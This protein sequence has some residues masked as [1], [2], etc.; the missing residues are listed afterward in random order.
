MKGRYLTNALFVLMHALKY[1]ITKDRIPLMVSL[2][3][4]NLCN[5]DCSFCY[6]KNS[7]VKFSEYST[8]ELL[9]YIDQFVLLG[10]RIFLLQGGEPLLRQDLKE[11]ISRIRHREAFCR[12][13][14]NGVLVAQ[15]IDSLTDADQISFSLDGNQEVADK[16]R[17]SGVY[18]KVLEGMEEAFKRKIPFEIHASLIRESATHKDSVFHLLELARRFRT[19]V[20][21]CVSCVSGAQNT[22]T[23]GSADLTGEEIKDFYRFLIRLKKEKYPVG[24]SFNSLKKS[25]NWPISYSEIG[26]EHNLPVGF[27]FAP[28]RHGR[29]ICWLG[30]NHTLLPCP[31]AFSRPEYEVPI[32][33]HHIKE[34]WEELGRRATC[35]ACSGS[36]ESTSLFNL[37]ME[38]LVSTG[39]QYL[40]NYFMGRRS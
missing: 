20:S 1:K 22:Q 31:I 21:F 36:D 29:L 33:N 17:G 13:S 27:R 37:K 10:T 30:A 39:A 9:D 32:R 6:F 4:T 23:V 24:N 11:I 3:I 12:I 28:C 19:S 35:I 38:D 26:F 40:K 8:D 18:K 34:A 14:T 2:G 15:R 16:I 5:M 7:L 25:L